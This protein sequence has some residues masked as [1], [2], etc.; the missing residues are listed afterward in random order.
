LS[1]QAKTSGT[2]G[3]ADD[4]G[5]LTPL[6]LAAWRGFLDVHARIVRE[7]DEE[8]QRERGLPVS[9]YEVLLL[10]DGTPGGRLRMSDLA[11]STLLSLS[12]ASR[13]VDRLVREGLVT[14]APCPDD[15]RGAFAVISEEGRRRLADARPVHRAGVRRRFLDALDGDEMRALGELWGRLGARTREG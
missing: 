5:A 7:L 4:G 10:L 2:A 15:R 11:R 1:T 13:L 8:L 9:A 6:E 12:G 3:G 14:R